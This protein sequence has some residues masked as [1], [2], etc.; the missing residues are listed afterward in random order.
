MSADEMSKS[1]SVGVTWCMHEQP[2]PRELFP[3]KPNEE[4]HTIKPR[5][6]ECAE[7][8]DF[9]TPEKKIFMVIRYNLDF[10]HEASDAHSDSFVDEQTRKRPNKSAHLESETHSHEKTIYYI[11]NGDSNCMHRYARMVVKTNWRC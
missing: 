3:T 1:G 5:V 4:T 6:N 2:S 9:L 8:Y 7:G 11:K 10:N